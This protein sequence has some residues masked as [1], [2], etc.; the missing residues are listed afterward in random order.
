MP[1]LAE[2]VEI[3]ERVIK[4]SQATLDSTALD[5]ILRRRRANG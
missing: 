3:D 1:T 4:K 2:V 5:E